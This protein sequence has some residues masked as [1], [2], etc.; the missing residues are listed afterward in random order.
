MGRR[1]SGGPNTANFA[2]PDYDALFVRMRAMENGPE[3]QALIE[4]MRAITERQRPWI[5]LF[6][7][8]DYAVHHGWLGNVKPP[9]LSLPAMKYWDIDPAQR[10]DRRVAWNVPVRWP[11]YVLV[12]LVAVGLAYSWRRR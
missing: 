10:A 5:E 2:D 6:H 7:P 3:R 4:Q 8:E 9:S 11:A 1:A 12:G